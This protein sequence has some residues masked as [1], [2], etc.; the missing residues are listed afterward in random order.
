MC[1]GH[2]K[3]RGTISKGAEL[4]HEEGAREVYACCTHGVF[5]YNFYLKKPRKYPKRLSISTPRL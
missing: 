4:L 3:S 1:F 5:R 2:L